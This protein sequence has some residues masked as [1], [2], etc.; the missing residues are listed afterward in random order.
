MTAHWTH[1][2][3]WVKGYLIPGS[4]GDGWELT[5]AETKL[6]LA[7][8]R[9]QAARLNV[10]L[11]VGAL[12]PDARAARRDI[13]QMINADG[14]RAGNADEVNLS[15]ASRPCGFTVC[16]PRGAQ[17]AQEALAAALTSILELGAPLALYQLPQITQNEMSAEL[18][19]SLAA[20][21]G[22]FF[23]FKDSSGADRVA[24]SGQVPDDVFLVRGAEGDYARWLRGTGGPYDGLL[25]STANCFA[26]EL[27][28]MVECLAAGRKTEAGQIST[29]LTS[30]VAE[31]FRLVADVGAG[32]AFA[33]ANKAL[34]HFFAFGPRSAEVAP[35]RLH[36]GVRL[37]VEVIRA[38]GETLAHHGLIP[39][40]GYL[41]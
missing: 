37:P 40:R 5:E 9:E 32:N 18:V 16:P 26:R 31:A 19:A 1:L 28:Q 11:L 3:P 36:A 10:H 41:E 14:A 7:F 4:T 38:T 20:R 27:A 34:D 23:L 17:L 33:N 8:A 12:N 21:F 29:K 15:R 30:V 22:N 24:L 2:A 25:L 6:V 35:P 13:E 39:R